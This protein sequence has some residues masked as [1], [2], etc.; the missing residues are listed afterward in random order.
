MKEESKINEEE[1]KESK[2]SK[3]EESPTESK[4]KTRKNRESNIQT[5][6]ELIAYCNGNSGGKSDC[7]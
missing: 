3:K 2:K 1:K 5:V 6:K 7:T 4:S